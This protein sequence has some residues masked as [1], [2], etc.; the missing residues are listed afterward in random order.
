MDHFIRTYVA[1][2]FSHKI[3]RCWTARQ[4]DPLTMSA[5]N[6]SEFKRLTPV[7]VAVAGLIGSSTLFLWTSSLEREQAQVKFEYAASDRA[8]AVKR[9]IDKSFTWIYHPIVVYEGTLQ[10]ACT[11]TYLLLP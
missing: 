10:T 8:L 4:P 2:R 11:P 6:G 3:T 7:V 1:F 9:G 5:M